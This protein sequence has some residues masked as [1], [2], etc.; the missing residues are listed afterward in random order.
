MNASDQNEA[1]S[2]RS[3]LSLEQY[4]RVTAHLAHFVAHGSEPVLRQLGVATPLWVGA[5]EHWLRALQGEFDDDQAPLAVRFGAAFA[6]AKDE[7]E[8]E[9]PALDDVPV[10]LEPPKVGAEFESVDETTL[11]VAALAADALPFASS[12][13]TTPPLPTAP[14]E[15]NDDVG[16]TQ[17]AVRALA[18]PP[19][20]LP[21]SGGDEPGSDADPVC[22]A[23]RRAGPH[24]RPAGG[25]SCS[26]RRT[27]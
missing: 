12:A 13:G 23:T 14:E 2:D 25:H 9:R 5:K 24:T 16:M 7:L 8:R 21:F 1:Q 6:T 18:P 17:L 27:E 4:A 22:I 20:A 19:K 11:G 26:L 15:R 10:L 3:V